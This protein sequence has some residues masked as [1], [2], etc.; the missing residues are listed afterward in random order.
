M[1]EASTLKIEPAMEPN[2]ARK[3]TAD[4]MPMYRIFEQSMP[5]VRAKAVSNG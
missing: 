3:W 2:A 5:S 4:L 1:A